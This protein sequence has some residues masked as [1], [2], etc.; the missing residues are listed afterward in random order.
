MCLAAGNTSVEVRPRK[1]D[2]ST[3]KGIAHGADN[4]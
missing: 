1:L 4:D 3:L 2:A